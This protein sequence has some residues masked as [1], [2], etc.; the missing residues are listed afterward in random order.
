MAVNGINY[1]KMNREFRVQKAALTRAIN[2]KD[3]QKVIDT[4]IK[5]IGQWDETGAWPDDWARWQRALDDAFSAH[6]SAY[7]EGDRDDAP[8]GQNYDMDFL[9]QTARYGVENA[10]R[11]A[12]KVTKQR[13]YNRL[14]DAHVYISKAIKLLDSTEIG[15]DVKRALAGVQL[16]V[17]QEFIRNR[18][19]VA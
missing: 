14:G 8:V 13:A 9:T 3:P 17:S 7:V 4:T 18:P 1:D 19:E 11:Q 5:T 16:A 10:K 12:E 2:S 15:D 6:R